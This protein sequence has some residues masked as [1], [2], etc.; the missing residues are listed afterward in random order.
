MLKKILVL[1]A[2]ALFADNNHN[3][4]KDKFM[5]IIVIMLYFAIEAV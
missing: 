1:K 5:K 3:L 4:G 2:L